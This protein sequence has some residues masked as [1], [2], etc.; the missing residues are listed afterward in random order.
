MLKSFPIFKKNGAHLVEK[1]QPPRMCFHPLTHLPKKIPQSQQNGSKQYQMLVHYWPQVL[2][3]CFHLC[4]KISQVFI[5][6]LFFI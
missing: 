1:K 6:I 5:W 3:L 4:I 2:D